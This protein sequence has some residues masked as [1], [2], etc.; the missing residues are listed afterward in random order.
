MTKAQSLNINPLVPTVPSVGTPAMIRSDRLAAQLG[1]HHA[2]R[3][4]FMVLA[5]RLR[6]DGD[7]S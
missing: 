5:D 1:S 3:S 7:T 2:T 4:E 6:S